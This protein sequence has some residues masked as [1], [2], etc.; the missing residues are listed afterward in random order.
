MWLKGFKGS[1][2]MQLENL[3]MSDDIHSDTIFIVLILHLLPPQTTYSSLPPPSANL[4]ATTSTS[5]QISNGA[6]CH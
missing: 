3:D 6:D 2:S 4:S 5:S 1:E